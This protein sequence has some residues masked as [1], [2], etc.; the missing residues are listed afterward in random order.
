M[1]Y[2]RAWGEE[3][4]DQKEFSSSVFSVRNGLQNILDSSVRSALTTS[5]NLIATG[6]WCV[7][8]FIGS[9]A[10]RCTFLAY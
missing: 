3:I 10:M 1:V 5:T 6:H 7:Q 2:K 8:E 9:V 4:I